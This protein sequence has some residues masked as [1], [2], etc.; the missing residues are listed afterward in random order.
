MA[1]WKYGEHP[2]KK[3]VEERMQLVERIFERYGA[4]PTD[5]NVEGR[6]KFNYRTVYY[7]KGDYF[8]VDFIPFD[9]KPY[10]VIEWTDD[11]KYAE[12]GSLEDVEPFPY[13]LEDAEF[14][15]EVRYAF[16][17]EP[18]PEAYPEYDA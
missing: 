5:M 3:Y 4:I 8:R 1:Q 15:K 7:Y 10:I 11:K 14:D 13:D 2:T 9:D 18:Y 12:A 16:E 6:K 17:I